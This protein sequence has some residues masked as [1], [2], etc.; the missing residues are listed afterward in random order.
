MQNKEQSV[1]SVQK[2]TIFSLV[3]KHRKEMYF[4]VKQY[5]LITQ[6][7]DIYQNRPIKLLSTAKL[8]KNVIVDVMQRIN[9]VT[10]NESSN[11]NITARK[12]NI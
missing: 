11:S 8:Y 7:W 6:R 5:L 10:K 3:A 9:E 4:P 1:S 2:F 12:R